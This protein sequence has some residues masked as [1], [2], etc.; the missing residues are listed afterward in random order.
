MK[1]DVSIYL[2]QTASHAPREVSQ[3]AHRFVR[4]RIAQM[5]G[6]DPERL[7][8]VRTQHGKPCVE[9]SSIWFNLS[10]SGNVVAAAFA[11]CEIGVDI[12]VV[13]PINLRIAE[14]Y[15]AESDRRYLALAESEQDRLNRFFALWTAK[16]AYLKRH[17]AGL[18]GGLDFP[19]A[20][21]NGLL[22]TVASESFPAAG[23]FYRS[24]SG[25]NFGPNARLSTAGC[26]A[27]YSLSLC[28]DRLN[29][30]FLNMT[31]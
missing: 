3:A 23:I 10:H 24:V 17:G 11:E 30:V 4:E 19:V 8:F 29:D 14:R 1:N 31:I 15:F 7:V 20:D 12:E 16:E 28:A 18:S 6:E 22:T 27:Q 5:T 25:E 21:E 26:S 9:N 2:F 13:R